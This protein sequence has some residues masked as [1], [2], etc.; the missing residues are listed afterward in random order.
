M[1]TR[2]TGAVS[3]RQ[4]GPCLAAEVSGMDLTRPLSPEEVGAVHAGMDRYAVLVFHDQP[5]TDEQQLGFT[6]SLG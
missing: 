4:V 6:R 5:L 3:F 1:A 2:T